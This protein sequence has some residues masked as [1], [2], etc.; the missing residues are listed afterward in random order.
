M[1]TLS[2]E[3]PSRE[4]VEELY[5][6]GFRS[7]VVHHRGSVLASSYATRLHRALARGGFPHLVEI[8]SSR[9]ATA[10]A[11]ELEARDPRQPSG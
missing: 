8:G 11:I 4:A 6:I 7:I 3:L 10:Y 5:Q 1:R 9:D 2:R